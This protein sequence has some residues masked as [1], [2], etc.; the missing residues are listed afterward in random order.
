MKKIIEL[1]HHCLDRLAWRHSNKRMDALIA[2]WKGNKQKA[3]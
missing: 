1:F 2:H 3:A